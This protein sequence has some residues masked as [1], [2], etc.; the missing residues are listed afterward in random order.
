MDE[1]VPGDTVT[2]VIPADGWDAP[3]TVTV[4]VADFVVSATLVAV[5]FP[6]PPVA[7]A[8]NTPAAVIVPIVV[9]QVTPWFVVLPWIVALNWT[10]ALG[11][12]V[13][14]AG[15]TTMELTAGVDVDPLPCRGSVMGRWVGSVKNA[16]LPVTFPVLVA[17]NLT[18]KFA[19]C[20]AARLRGVVRPLRLKP[21]PF[22]T[23][24]L[25]LTGV[26]P[27]FVKVTGSELAVPTLAV[28]VRLSGATE[29]EGSGSATPAQPETQYAIAN[30]SPTSTRTLFS[31]TKIISFRSPYYQA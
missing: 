30:I 26:A 24:W 22:K 23:A 8:V 12:G 29:S 4:A 27:V 7:G 17:A 2:E 14:T 15:E 19:L 1:A 18:L 13:A 10:V 11:A 9:V 20:P 31:C 6:V 5:I 25:T 28:T 3:P 21:E 16:T